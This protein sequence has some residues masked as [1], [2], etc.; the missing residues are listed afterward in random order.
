MPVNELVQE[1]IDLRSELLRAGVKKTV[2]Q[3]MRPLAIPVGEARRF[4]IAVGSD[5]PPVRIGTRCELMGFRVI[6]C[7]DLERLV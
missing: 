6:I 5:Q 4:Q 1:L 2:I 3:N 7:E